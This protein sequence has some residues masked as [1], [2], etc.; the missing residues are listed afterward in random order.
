MS[1]DVPQGDRTLSDRVAEEIRAL[2][3]RKRISGAELARRL[4]VSPMWISYRLAGRQEIGLTDL[5]RISRIL[6]VEPV[7]LLAS[8]TVSTAGIKRSYVPGSVRPPEHRSKGRPDSRNSDR[9][10]GRVDGRNNDRRSQLKRALTPEE[11]ALIAA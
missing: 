7:D 8:A 6:D 3:A 2:M 4:E 10:K 5:E 1:I 11:K 9:P